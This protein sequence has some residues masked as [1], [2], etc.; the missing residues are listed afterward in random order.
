[1]FNI[2]VQLTEKQG[3]G[4]EGMENKRVKMVG[5]REAGVRRRYKDAGGKH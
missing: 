3:L 4:K 5:M 1:M 2:F